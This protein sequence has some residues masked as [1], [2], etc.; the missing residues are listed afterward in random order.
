MDIPT[1]SGGVW[2][3]PGYVANPLVF[4]GTVGILPRWA[5]TKSVQNGDLVVV[6][7]GATGRD[8]IHGAT[9]SSAEFRSVLTGPGGWAMPKARPMSNSR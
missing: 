6:V 3:H 1:V 5:A 2:S 8:G 7:G 9:F 4:A